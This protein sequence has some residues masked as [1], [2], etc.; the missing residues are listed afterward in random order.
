[1]QRKLRLTTTIFIGI[2][3]LYFLGARESRIM[4]AAPGQVSNL[5]GA[6][7][8]MGL[9]L[10]PHLLID[11]YLIAGSTNVSRVVNHLSG[12]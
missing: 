2:L 12:T 9:T 11:D 1:M 6:T 3:V 7:D 4:S 8:A 5:H 10:G